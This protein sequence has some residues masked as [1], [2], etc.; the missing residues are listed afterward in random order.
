[1][2]RAMGADER[3]FAPIPCV[4][5]ALPAPGRLTHFRPATFA[6]DPDGRLRASWM[7]NQGSGDFTA[8]GRAQGF[9]EV[10]AGEV[11]VAAGT[12]LKGWLW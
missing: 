6:F 3:T 4:A 9:V 10:P 11:P 1:L 5:D 8:W 2:L 7:P 12:V